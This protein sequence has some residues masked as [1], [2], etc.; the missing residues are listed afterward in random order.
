MEDAE[1]S[2]MGTAG[3]EKKPRMNRSL[4]DKFKDRDT[5]G[6]LFRK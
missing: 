2:T 5:V 4:Q 3:G 1:L 6:T